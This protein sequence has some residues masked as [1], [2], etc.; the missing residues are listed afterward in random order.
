MA[1][2]GNGDTATA[3]LTARAPLST[4]ASRQGIMAFY[5]N[6]ELSYSRWPGLRL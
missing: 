2:L 5:R 4:A 1:Q 3:T 6:G